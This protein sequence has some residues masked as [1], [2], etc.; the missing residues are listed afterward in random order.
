MSY[1]KISNLSVILQEGL[2]FKNM[3]NIGSLD[4]DDK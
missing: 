2:K 4:F 1:R 3:K